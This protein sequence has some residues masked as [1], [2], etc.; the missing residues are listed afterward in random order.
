MYKANQYMNY[1]KQR[2]HYG[3]KGGSK[4]LKHHKHYLLNESLETA[5][6]TSMFFNRFDSFN[7]LETS[8]AW[9]SMN[10]KFYLNQ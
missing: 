4:S 2:I 7:F 3:G 1:N 10:A 5:S 8:E 6:R 9:L